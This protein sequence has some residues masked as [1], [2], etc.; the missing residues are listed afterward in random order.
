MKFRFLPLLAVAGM[1]GVGVL[2]AKASGA[3]F[4]LPASPIS[5]DPDPIPVARAPYDP[6]L[7]H[8]SLEF[9]AAQTRYDPGNAIFL[10]QLA[11]QYLDSYRETG[12]SADA[13]RAEQA[14]RASLAARTNHNGDAMFQ[15]SRALLT[16]HR[17]SEALKYAR[18]DAANDPT[19]LRECA[20]IEMELGDYDAAQRDI[21]SCKAIAKA[22]AIQLAALPNNVK[23]DKPEDD[24]AFLTLEA[25]LNELHGDT[26]GQLR[27]LSQATKLADA[28]IEMPV[29][30]IAWFHERLGRCLFMMG[31]L[32]EAHASYLVGLQAFPRDYRTL[33]ALAHLEAARGNWAKTIEWGTRA[34]QIVPSP[35]TLALLGDAYAALGQQSRAAAQYRLVEQIG[36]LARA[37]GVLYDRQLSLFYADHG[38]HLSEAVTIARGE[39]RAR[40]DIYAYDTLAWTLFKANRLE[41]AAQNAKRATQFGTRDA[42][43]WFHAGEI[44]AAQGQTA[45]ARTYLERALAINPQFHP[46]QPATAR[47]TLARL[48]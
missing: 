44:A 42:S 40:H 13:T 32:D 19:G 29:E 38:R 15:L 8:K 5:S 28:N 9:Y 17:F 24:P 1:F 36:G 25:R 3:P 2:W 43:L 16:Q 12:D 22:D 18:L 47:E 20:D 7:V 48:K 30:S 14:A 35:E 21:E 33:A 27:L 26:E 34:A 45:L 23:A 46:T 10:A 11:A 31:R 6:T 37:Q 4:W 41:E 39:L